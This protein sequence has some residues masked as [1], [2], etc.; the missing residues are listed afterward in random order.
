[1]QGVSSAQLLCLV[2]LAPLCGAFSMNLSPI[3]RCVQLLQNLGKQI[4]ADS[5]KEEEMYET[6]MCWGQKVVDTKSASNT[7]AESR[8]EM[9]KQYLADID[10]GR[11]EFTSERQDLEKE[12]EEL[13]GDLEVA[14]NMR[15]QENKDF[16]VA[17]EEMKKAVTA[18]TS[19]V[20]VLNEA[21]KNNTKSALFA[22]KSK[23]NQ[24]FA[25]R[26]AE[27]ASLNQ[28]VELGQK[29]LTKGD[30]FFLR[31][32][33]TGEV[34][35]AD[36]KKLNRK[37]DFKMS[38][39]SR[40]TKIQSVL[41]KLQTTFQANLDDATAK[42][43]SAKAS[44][45]KL[46][47]TK[48]G[49]LDKAQESLTKM[50]KENGAKGMSKA[51]AQEEVDALELQVTDD[52]KFI[53]D[54]QTSMATKK[55][56]W[57]ER[58][59][60]R[61]GEQQAISQA[62][63]ILAS[64]EAKD[65]F[66]KSAA[67]QGF[68]FLQTAQNSALA[69]R[70]SQQIQDLARV[71]NDKRLTILAQSVA[72]GHFDAVLQAIDKMIATLK[73][74][75]KTDL[76]NKQGCESDRMKDTR[77]AL[78]AGQAIDDMTDSITRLTAEI[79]ELNTELETT[80]TELKAARDEI[81]EAKKIREAE[82][83]E[84]KTSDA[85]DE[86]ASSTVGDAMDVLTKFYKDNGLMSFAQ[87]GAQAPPPPPATWEGDYKGKT[88]GAAGIIGILKLCQEDIDKDRT[89]AK[90]AEDKAQAAYD[91]AFEAFEAEEKALNTAIGELSGQIGGR[92]T[93]VETTTKSRGTKHGEME[94]TL[95]KI[96]N[97]NPGCD[98]IEVN[99]PLRLK[100]RQTEIDGLLKA[101]A[102]L[103]GAAFSEPA[104]P[105]REVK[106]GDALLQRLRRH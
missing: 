12:I 26:A 65:N 32:L 28:A 100:N 49:Q 9:L 68:F 74:D 19:A 51:D 80:K 70:A 14:K 93:E 66:K 7:A 8:V 87:K 21:I 23:V 79:K 64:D 40:S 89:S 11:V 27:G 90:T 6:Y 41:K 42:E 20:N 1:M 38:Y 46:K 36:W 63:S 73:D 39:K 34:P 33:L 13:T 18:L 56:E 15:T 75:E 99:Y 37:A 104:D 82:N 55:T 76:T 69:K 31:R 54:T 62:V 4:E 10:A 44:Y 59:E 30:A 50:E 77:D 105:N 71:T 102:I 97:A 78:V 45:D 25:E 48:Q 95:E 96:E 86:Q 91:K 85:D 84:W 17:E 16:Q 22:M 35:K 81:A 5:K 98:Y 92:E 47:G 61:A 67:S 57:K 106:P 72:G 88:G 43:A 2:V 52:T 103:S 94:A 3:S 101:K 24:G 60:L 53:G 58:Q 83:T 29:F